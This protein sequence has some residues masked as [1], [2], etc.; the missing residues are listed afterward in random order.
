MTIVQPPV[1]ARTSL[2]RNSFLS[3]R[4]GLMLGTALGCSIA[5]LASPAAALD[6]CGANVGGNPD[7]VC[8]AVSGVGNPYPTGINYNGLPGEDLTILIM[9]DVAV[10]APA[11]DGVRAFGAAGFDTDVTLYSGAT[12]DTNEDGVFAVASGAGGDAFVDSAADINAGQRGILAFAADGYATI[13]NSGDIYVDGASA[14]AYSDGLVAVANFGGVLV[15]NSGGITVNANDV[16]DFGIYAYGYQASATVINT[17]DI[18]VT[19]AVGT[20]TGIYANASGVAEPVIVYSSGIID[21]YSAGEAQGVEVS[22]DFTADVSVFGDITAES[23][24]GRASAITVNAADAVTINGSADLT[25]YADSNLFNNYAVSA[26]TVAAANGTIDID[27]TGDITAIGG[28]YVIGAYASGGGDINIDVNGTIQ[29]G[30]SADLAG[31]TVN[32]WG[33]YAI[34]TAGNDITV[35]VDD[36]LVY[37]DGSFLLGGGDGI[38]AYTVGVTNI[39]ANDI[40]T[41]G[42]YADGVNAGGR[43]DIGGD[44]Y[45]TVSSINTYGFGSDGVDV[46]AHG[47]VYVT[48]GSVYTAG[49]N[50]DGIDLHSDLGNLYS[51][52]GSIVTVGANSQGVVAL[53]DAGNALIYATDVSVYGL[54]SDAIRVVTGGAG[55]AFASVD[56]RVYSADGFGVNVVSGD[57]ATVSIALT[58]SVYGFDAGVSAVS[59]SGTTITNAGDISGGAGLAINVDGG[60]ASLTNAAG[61]AIYGAVNL[62][63]NADTFANAGTFEA[64]G[65]SDFGLGADLLTNTGVVGAERYS[66]VAGTVTFNGLETFNN[67]G[68]LVSMTD[69]QVGDRLVLAGTTFNGTG[70]SRLGLDVALGGPGS[71]A[72]VLQITGA[73]QFTGVTTIQPNDTL[74]ASPGVLNFGGILVVDSSNA[75]EL[76]SEF[77]M[78]NVDKGFVEYS[79]VFDAAADNWLIVGLPDDEA[80]ELLAVGQAAGD[81][82][83]RSGDAWGARMQEVRDSRGSDTPSRQEGW[84]FWMQA[85]GGDESF[86]NL[87]A[88]TISG[89]TFAQN[90]S[91][92]S[93]WRGLQIGMD[94]LSG[95]FIWGL[96]GGFVQQETRFQADNNSLDFE[97]FNVG[98]YAGMNFGGLYMNGLVKGDFFTVD[99]N[100]TSIPSFESM[101]GTTYGAQGEIG[102]RFDM[103]GMFLEP[104]AQIAWSS[105][106]IDDGNAIGA[107]FSFNNNESLYGKVGGRI[108]GTFGSGDMIVSPYVGAYAVEEFEG[109]NSLAFNTGPTGFTV[110]NEAR[111]SYG[112]AE[113]GMTT[114]SFYGL[115]GFVKGEW[116]FGGDASGGAVRLGARW[117]W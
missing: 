117:T 102:Y 7:A 53:A 49:D 97:G 28:N 64:Y 81:F 56:G 52:T 72:D 47:D 43:L 87:G 106:D 70:N 92:D 45:I 13:Y 65:T 34:N 41:T 116:N 42:Y 36:V 89:A 23:T 111:G 62:T 8:T 74:A 35:N 61:G 98:A 75:A 19:N 30:D 2:R 103:G 58:G 110:E 100:F 51:Y 17:G 90:L 40:V 25:S 83:R 14:A 55:D 38:W 60:A 20:G 112:Q 16:S 94:T 18:T 67:A 63:D 54:G 3:A 15:N 5:I 24:L 84:E 10:V 77:A 48:V 26:F 96:T 73:G 27:V 59:L 39:T 113:L 37:Q 114:Q 50:A 33:V 93:D 68:G 107:D 99:A 85:H 1:G 22:S 9:G 104:H 95:N 109:R 115:Q 88:F 86:D 80:F 105:T 82:W 78:V 57:F 32:G 31:V 101:D 4:T 91:T 29:V 46:G 66:G 21:V 108:G 6:E 69:G 12:I 79:L 44:T 71:A 11:V 76:G